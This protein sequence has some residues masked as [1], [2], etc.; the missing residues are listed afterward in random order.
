MH[1]WLIITGLVIWVVGMFPAGH[2]YERWYLVPFW[3]LH[4]LLW[5]LWECPCALFCLLD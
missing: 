2:A 5:I 3:P 1:P 4:A